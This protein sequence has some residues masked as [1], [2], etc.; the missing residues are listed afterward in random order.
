MLKRI[1][2]F[3]LIGGLMSS[4]A[5]DNKN[6]TSVTTETL[7]R[8]YQG[9]N[10]QGNYIWAG[11]MNLAW[12]EMS[13]QVIGAPIQVK[14]NLQ[15][16]QN[17]IYSYNHP[18]FTK[19]DIS[20]DSY[21]IKSGYGQKTIDA[22]NQ[23]VKQKFPQKSFP[24]L[25]I[26]LGDKDIISY[27]YLLKEVQYKTPFSI[28]SLNFNGQVVQAFSATNSEMRNNIQI[29]DYDNDDRFIL[30]LKLKDTKDELFLVKGYENSSAKEIVQLINKNNIN[31]NNTG[32]FELLDTKDE[33][34][35]PKLVLDVGHQHKELINVPIAN[36][37]F[38][39]YIIGAMIENIKFNMNEVG[40]K[41][42]NEAYIGF[43]A[44]AA[45]MKTPKR[46]ILDKPYWV[47]MKDAQGQSPYFILGVKNSELMQRVK[48]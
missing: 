39:N 34:K 31:K 20:A 2:I 16:I 32:N 43:T 19:K 29:L 48:E 25:K 21:Y 30:K 5:T 38:E 15:K 45:V 17:K 4:C 1:G 37:G 36:A 11:A 12:T 28:T 14:S 35:A 27:A 7:Q 6:N 47:I 8:D 42:E 24:D 9:F 41:V 13:E 3:L 10:Y 18:V 46:L 26:K 40:A 22:I 44:T 23:E 33:F